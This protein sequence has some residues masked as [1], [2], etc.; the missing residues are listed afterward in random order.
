[1]NGEGFIVSGGI[2]VM[3]A[4][5]E[6]EEDGTENLWPM[7]MMA[8]SWRGGNFGPRHA[9]ALYSAVGAVALFAGEPLARAYL[10]L[11]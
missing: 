1:M 8:G 2:P 5:L 6:H 7:A 3:F 11:L 9:L 4:P 10:Q